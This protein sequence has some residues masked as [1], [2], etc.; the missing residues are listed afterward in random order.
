MPEVMHQP[1]DFQP[2]LGFERRAKPRI[3]C[4]YPAVLRGIN[5]DGSKFQAAASLANMSVAGMYLRTRQ[6]V[7]LKELLVVQVRLSTTP[8]GESNAPQVIA[9]GKVVRLE[10]QPDGSF[11]VAIALSSYRLL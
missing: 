1:A 11:G 7:H 3:C 8:L 9:Q 5:P 4:T 6:I 2:W 10:A